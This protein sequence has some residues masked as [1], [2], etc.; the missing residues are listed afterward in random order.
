VQGALRFL[1]DLVDDPDDW[2]TS[3]RMLKTIVRMKSAV[4]LATRRIVYLDP[5]VVLRRN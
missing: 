4:F 3:S 5:I 1:I 2:S